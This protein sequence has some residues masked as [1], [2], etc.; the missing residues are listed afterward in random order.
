MLLLRPAASAVAAWVAY[1]A[2]RRSALN[3]ETFAQMRMISETRQPEGDMQQLVPLVSEKLP[4]VDSLPEGWVHWKGDPA[5]KGPFRT[6]KEVAYCLNEDATSCAL[7]T[8]AK[9][10][11]ARSMREL[12]AKRTFAMLMVEDPYERIN[13][14]QNIDACVASDSLTNAAPIEGTY[15]FCFR[16]YVN[17]EEMAALMI[18]RWGIDI[19]LLN[20]KRCDQLVI[21]INKQC[22]L[23]AAGTAFGFLPTSITWEGVVADN[24]IQWTTTS[25]RVGWKRFGKTFDRP[26]AAEKLRTDPWNIYFPPE[27]QENGDIVV[28]HRL[29][30]G[31]LVF[32]RDGCLN[33]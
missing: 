11:A 19:I 22:K 8:R 2:A 10:P 16:D 7:F 33:Q 26:P 13:W 25:A 20:P 21:D 14:M 15:A 31:K 1:S 27:E 23:D 29:G 24:A 5:L 3:K 18:K 30:K 12:V 32:A 28:F 9:L 17:Y 6:T 4:L